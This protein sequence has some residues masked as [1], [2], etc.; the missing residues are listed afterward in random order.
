MKIYWIFT[1][2]VKSQRE[3]EHVLKGDCKDVATTLQTT[4]SSFWSS[5]TI[6]LCMI[7]RP[8]ELLSTLAPMT[9]I[10]WSIHNSVEKEAS[11]LHRRFVCWFPR[12]LL[13]RLPV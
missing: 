13:G 12:S 4:G 9:L 1:L 2:D 10:P 11:L 8:Q 5:Q 6:A 7:L 3:K